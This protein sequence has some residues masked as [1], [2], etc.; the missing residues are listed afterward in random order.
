MNMQKR[1]NQAPLEFKIAIVG[2]GPAGFYALDALVKSGR[3]GIMIDMFEQLP[4]PYG[5]VRSGVAPDH[6]DIKSVTKIYERNA[7]KAKFRFFGNVQVGQDLQKGDLFKHYH[8]IIYSVGTQTDRR[9]EIPGESLKGCYAAKDFVGWYN[10]HP[11]FRDA[12]FNFSASKVAIIGMGNV[13]ADVARMLVTETKRFAKTDIADYALSDLQRNKAKDVY[14]IARRGVLQSAITPTVIREFLKIEG[15]DMVINP[16]DLELDNASQRALDHADK[17]MIQGFEMLQFL[18]QRPIQGHPKRIHFLFKRS[19]TEVLGLD[20]KVCGLR[21][22]H[23]QLVEES[24][25]AIKAVPTEHY[26]ELKVQSIYRA[27]GY[28]G[29]PIPHVSFDPKRGIIPNRQ[30]RVIDLKTGAVCPGEYVTGWVKRGPSGVIGSNKADAA[31]TISH[32]LEDYPETSQLEPSEIDNKDIVAWLKE[33]KIPYTTF[34]DWK[35]IDDTE[36]AIG[37]TKGKPRDKFSI[38]EQMLEL[39]NTHRN[40]SETNG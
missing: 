21:L 24:G 22:V 29:I 36:R 12:S 2:S 26:E 19:P 16:E 15:V 4:T 35:F 1:Q 10:A 6:Q 11:H 7:S 40:F 17:E 9:M 39:I 20:H 25:G 33:N 34:G 23:N 38:V 30:G 37:A 13:A 8:V 14:L 5:L 32:I 3:R 27:I 18:S 28:L 31:E